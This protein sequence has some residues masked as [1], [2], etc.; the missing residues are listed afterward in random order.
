[1]PALN[2]NKQLAVF[3]AGLLLGALIAVPLAYLL[4]ARES[5]SLPE[6]R[7]QSLLDQSQKALADAHPEQS[8]AALIEARRLAPANEAVQNNL[9]VAFTLLH[10]FDEAMAA[11]D[12]ALRVKPD[13]QLALNNRAWATAER[14]K[15]A[16]AAP[17]AH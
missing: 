15:A 12:A 14:A 1:M 17:A 16:A 8:L 6:V 10:R 9:C 7:I 5:A 4:P 11:C 13:F 3:A 2:D